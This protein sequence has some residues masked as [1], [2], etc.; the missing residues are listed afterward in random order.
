MDD[1]TKLAIK[2]TRAKKTNKRITEELKERFGDSIKLHCN[3][4]PYNYLHDTT[5]FCTDCFSS[6]VKSPHNLIKSKKGCPNCW[7]AKKRQAKEMLAAGWSQDD[8]ANQLGVTSRTLRTW[9]K[10]E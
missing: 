5:F 6:F 2:R 4:A 3:A 9:V 8:A 10:S 7:E 1:K